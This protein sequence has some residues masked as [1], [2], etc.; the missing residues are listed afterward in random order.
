MNYAERFQ[1]AASVA[2][3]ESREYAA[4]SYAS[5]IWELQKP[6]LQKTVADLCKNKNGARLLDFACGTGRVISDLENFAA[7]A[8]GLDISPEMV[9]VAKTKCR[10]T[11]FQIGDILAQPELLN[12][13]YDIITA[14]RFLLNTEPEIRL[15]VL[16]KL[17]S[18]LD[19][20]GWLI[21]NVH[22]SSRSLRHPAIWWRR[23]S[24]NANEMLNELSPCETQNLF[25]E[26]GFEIVRRIGFGILPPTLYRTPLR[27]AAFA[28]DRSLAGENCSSAISIDV[29]YVCHPA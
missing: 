9:E 15:R 16:K 22:G 23:H 18:A 6:V 1:D 3:Y 17:R 11:R 21:A 2:D 10:K 29:L 13:K 7:E 28:F 20:D 14:F 4:D 25:R 24:K 8:D 27:G 12:K 19:T 26:A 5:R